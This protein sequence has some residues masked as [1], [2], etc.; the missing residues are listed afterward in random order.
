MGRAREPGR[1][2]SR[3]DRF[4]ERVTTLG[5]EVMAKKGEQF[6]RGRDVWEAIRDLKKA[7][8]EVGEPTSG[9]RFVERMHDL[10]G[11]NDEGKVRLSLV[12]LMQKMM[13]YA[14]E[15]SLEERK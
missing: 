11:M 13:S 12:D 4:V 10:N 6:Y 9:E 1:E 15:R 5:R 7:W 3:W 2:R 8:D 14:R